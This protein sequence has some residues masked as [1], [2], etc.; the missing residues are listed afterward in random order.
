MHLYLGKAWQQRQDLSIVLLVVVEPL[1]AASAPKHHHIMSI[2]R[3][4][5][6]LRNSCTL[7]YICYAMTCTQHD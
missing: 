5:F 6:L 2:R 3:P 1:I 7:T 4:P